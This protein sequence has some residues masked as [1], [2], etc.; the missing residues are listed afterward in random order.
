ML[1]LFAVFPVFSAITRLG[2]IRIAIF[3]KHIHIF[4]FRSYEVI[5]L[6]IRFNANRMISVSYFGLVKSEP[7]IPRNL[8]VL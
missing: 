2:R 5:T 6:P 3:T 1:R 7:S 4:D 8:M